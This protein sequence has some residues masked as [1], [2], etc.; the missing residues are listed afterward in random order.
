MNADERRLNLTPGAKALRNSRE[1]QS[2]EPGVGM[3]G[4]GK[5]IRRFEDSVGWQKIR[6]LVKF[7]YEAGIDI[8]DRTK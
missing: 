6:E 5:K 4:G 1:S 3:K 2:R 8:Y 7:I